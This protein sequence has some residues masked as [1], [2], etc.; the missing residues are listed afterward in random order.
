MSCLLS[1]SSS[2]MIPHCAEQICRIIQRRVIWASEC[3]IVSG[4]MPPPTS[5]ICLVN[6]SPPAREAVNSPEWQPENQ[7]SRTSVSTLLLRSGS[8]L[9]S[10]LTSTLVASLDLPTQRM[11]PLPFRLVGL[12]FLWAGKGRWKKFGRNLARCCD[13]SRQDGDR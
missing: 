1:A 7:T 5:M 2:K 4:S 12:V 10:S 11:G 3:L 13:S 9:S 8:A 6:Y